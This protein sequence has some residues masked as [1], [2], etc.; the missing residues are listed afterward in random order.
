MRSLD[1]AAGLS[2]FSDVSLA[3]TT[4][5]A[6]C[7]AITAV[8]ALVGAVRSSRRKERARRL[9]IG[10]QVGADAGLTGA[11]M[12]NE[13]KLAFEEVVL[14]VTCG[15][16][17]R[18]ARQDVGVLPSGQDYLWASGS[19]HQSISSRPAGRP[20]EL[21]SGTPHENKPH[22][23]QVTFRNGKGFW[24]R[25]EA[26]VERVRSLVIWAEKTRSVT[27]ARYF[28][29]RSNFRRA[30]PV[31]VKVQPFERTEDLEDAFAKL[32]ATGDAPRGHDIPDVVVGPHDWIGRVAREESVIE[33]PISAQ[34]LRQ[35]SPV[36]LDALSRNGRLYGIPY[37]FDTVALIRNNALTGDGPMPTTFADVVAAGRAALRSK[38]IEDGV[39]LALQVGKPDANGNAGDPYHLWPLFSSLGGSFFGFREPGDDGDDRFDDI[40]VWRQGFVDA[41]VRLAELGR[42]GTLSS[43]LGRAEASSVFLEGRA[44][45]YVCSSRAL[46][47]I[48]ARHLDVTVSAVP[49]V[50]EQAAR[51]L[52]SAYGLFIYRGAPSLP[53]ARDLV[54]SYLSQPRAGLDL[55]RFQQ[56]VPVQEEAMSTVAERDPVLGPYVDQC[57]TGLIMPSRPE[58]REAW[59]LLGR[60]EYQVLAGDGDP[61]AL[62]EA[63]ATAGWELLGPVRGA[64]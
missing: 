32:A 36:A 64:D 3:A 9:K 28:G 15:L 21:G 18:E 60:T 44:P 8:T 33:P 6:I 40:S 58:M 57:R 29:R 17:G 16:H 19:V 47:A 26:Q 5:V 1:F 27:L 24:F 38:G 37:V 34:R 61:R 48:R 59:Q 30:Y 13:S 7:A 53:A 42:D 43:E 55:N 56:L 41:F 63:A 25:D 10:W 35:I 46:A 51:P 62:A 20:V 12:H 11:L 52:V 54:T 31:S 23:V 49:P 39:A 22:G 2:F 45:F 50:G 14:T 4:V